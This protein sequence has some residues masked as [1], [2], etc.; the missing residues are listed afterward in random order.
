MTQPRVLITGAGSGLGRALAHCYAGA[1]YAV[2]CAD[3]KP[4]TAEAT[5]AS[6]A[7]AGHLALPV[8][9]ADDDSVAL[10]EATL[11]REWDTL[12]VL[13]NNA[14]VASG[15]S[16]LEST[17]DEWRW[18]LDI[19]LLG[20]VR[21]SKAFVPWLVR[22]RQ[23]RVLNVA[24]FAALACAPNIMSYGA[25]KA[26]VLAL[27]EQLRAELHGHGITVSVACPSFFQ[28][29]LLDNFRAGDGG[30]MKRAATKLM[31]NARESAEQIAAEVFAQSERGRFMIIPTRAERVRWRLKRW[32]PELFFR[33][34]LKMAEVRT[35]SAVP[36]NGGAAR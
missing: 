3:V 8:D 28:T 14:G 1:G 29:N 20:V 36:G 9:I 7:G 31:A 13:V 10:L 27:S 25:T 18:M 32:F 11:A 22:R 5:R 4:A 12:D 30:R 19:N 16:L 23:G 33:K 24:S 35:M 15:G 6:L 17:L 21:V 34:L 26:A 2:A